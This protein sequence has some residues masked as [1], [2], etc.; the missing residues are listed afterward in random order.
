MKYL[1]NWIKKQTQ[2]GSIRKPKSG[3]IRK[4]NPFWQRTA[5]EMQRPEVQSLPGSPESVECRR[6]KEG[7]T[8]LEK[9][10]INHLM[11]QQ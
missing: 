4:P 5:E 2:H 1:S 6:R 3:S 8:T 9:R 10:E 7:L 11:A